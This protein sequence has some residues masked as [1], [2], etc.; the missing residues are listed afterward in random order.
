MIFYSQLIY[1]YF[2]ID[3]NMHL[4]TSTT[5]IYKKRKRIISIRERERE[6]REIINVFNPNFV[7]IV[8]CTF[9][10][11]YTGS[12][13]DGSKRFLWPPL[14]STKIFCG[15]LGTDV[16]FWTAFVVMKFLE[17]FRPIKGLSSFVGTGGLL[18]SSSGYLNCWSGGRSI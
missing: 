3:K 16:M 10:F 14:V 18:L 9:L 4:T 2:Q 12:K 7:N 15:C 11:V 1:F 8:I 5:F 13:P 17:V 6:D